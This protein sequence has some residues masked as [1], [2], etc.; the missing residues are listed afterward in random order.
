MGHPR[1]ALLSLL[2]AAA[3]VA[4]C[5]P[6][7]EEGGSIYARTPPQQIPTSVLTPF[8]TA[9][10]SSPDSGIEV[11]AA[12]DLAGTQATEPGLGDAFVASDGSG[13]VT[14]VDGVAEFP[15][16]TTATTIVLAFDRAIEASAPDSTTV[17]PAPFAIVTAPTQGVTLG[18]QY[19]I[20]V[21]PAP[22]PPVPGSGDSWKMIVTG[23]CID[24]LVLSTADGSLVLDDV[25]ALIFDTNALVPGYSPQG[26]VSCT[27]S[28]QVRHEH[29]GPVDPAFS[30]IGD[31]SPLQNAPDGESWPFEGAQVRS[32]STTLSGS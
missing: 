16:P 6:P 9:E 28:I 13:H 1:S 25:G 2:G 19:P 3:S 20:A 10:D 22:T 23:P 27:L 29:Y 14:L 8:F 5:T 7:D 15:R 11:Q 17:V 24:N 26:T 31:V 18:D 21:G 32:W 12:I 4:A 30:V